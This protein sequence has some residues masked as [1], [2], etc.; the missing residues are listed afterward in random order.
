VFGASLIIVRR[1][2]IITALILLAAAV[3]SLVA[4][5]VP[6]LRTIYW[7]GSDKKF[8]PVSHAG[9]AMFLGAPSLVMLGLFPG[10]YGVAMFWTMILGFILLCVGAWR[11]GA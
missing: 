6:G 9:V 11:D 8:G 2:K 7:K 10:R 1:M 5:R 3:Y 4:V